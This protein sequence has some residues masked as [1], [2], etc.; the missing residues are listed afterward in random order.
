MSRSTACQFRGDRQVLGAYNNQAIPA[1]AVCNGPNMLMKY[2]GDDMVEGENQLREFIRMLQAG[3]SQALYTLRLYEDHK[4]GSKIKANT[5]HDLSF[6]F[7]LWTDDED[8]PYARRR[9]AVNAQIEERFERLE[10]LIL[11]KPEEEEEE[12]GKEVSGVM[13][14]IS[15]ILKMPEVQ[16]QI[17]NITANVMKSI[18]NFIPMGKE[19]IQQ[20]AGIQGVDSGIK[21]EEGPDLNLSQ[22]Q[23]QHESDVLNA[24]VWQSLGVD[25]QRKILT[26]IR[27]LSAIDGELGDHLLQL[28]DLPE[29]KYRMALSFL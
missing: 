11:E 9:S 18:F 8:I 19:R 21:Q 12:Q 17:G 14:V 16:A 25:Q 13:S 23:A 26:A 28:A 20:V 10:K 3:E 27:K 29:K 1:F 7:S 6:N 5:A 4:A 24:Q 22:E 2:E 15:S